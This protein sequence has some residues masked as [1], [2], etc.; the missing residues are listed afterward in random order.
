MIIFGV[1]FFSFPLEECLW[2]SSSND[3]VSFFEK[4]F[5]FMLFSLFFNLKFLFSQKKRICFEGSDGFQNDTFFLRFKTILCKSDMG[6]PPR[7]LQHFS[8]FPGSSPGLA[9]FLIT[10]SS[11]WFSLL[12]FKKFLFIFSLMCYTIFVFF[13]RFWNLN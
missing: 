1:R 13:I 11:V 8:W 7:T 6:C 9:L 10:N 4:N 5:T 2:H 12:F 3:N